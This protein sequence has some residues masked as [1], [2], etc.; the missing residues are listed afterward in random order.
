M[1]SV[2]Y[3]NIKH[4]SINTIPILQIISREMLATT[5]SLK[6]TMELTLL[7]NIALK[8]F[9]IS[10]RVLPSHQWI[11]TRSLLPSSPS[12]ISKNVNIRSPKCHPARLSR[13]IHCS[14]FSSNR[15]Q[16]TKFSDSTPYQVDSFEGVNSLEQ[17]D[18][19]G[20][21]QRKQG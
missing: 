16:Q 14:R 7:F 8:T 20:G 13:I 1:G 12:W 10:F 6:A 21:N 4:E 18:T 5:R 3:M 2:T 9:H 17:C 11:L 15:L 19:R